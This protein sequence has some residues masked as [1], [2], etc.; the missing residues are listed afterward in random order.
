MQALSKALPQTQ[1][2]TDIA[3]P[4]FTSREYQSRLISFNISCALPKWLCIYIRRAALLILH[5]KILS[6]T[7]FTYTAF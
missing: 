3:R 6:K 5:E 1:H 4:L 2:Y 7:N